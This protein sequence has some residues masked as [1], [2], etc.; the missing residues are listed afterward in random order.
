MIEAD[1]YREYRIDLAQ[2]LRDD[3]F[4]W[5]RFFALV[6]GLSPQSAYGNAIA[7]RRRDGKQDNATRKITDA[8]EAT[9]YLMSLVTKKAG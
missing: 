4:S 8:Q 9:D 3:S 7:A 6:R 2:A 5:R 1:F